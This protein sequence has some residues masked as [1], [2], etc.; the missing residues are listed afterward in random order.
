MTQRHLAAWRLS[1]YVLLVFR[2]LHFLKYVFFVTIQQSVIGGH[3]DRCDSI[4][5][6]FG[7]IRDRLIDWAQLIYNTLNYV[8]GKFDNQVEILQL[9][10]IRIRGPH[11]A[12]GNIYIYDQGRKRVNCNDRD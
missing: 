8:F 10:Y 7:Y 4:C 6:H 5:S 12:I 3:L 1:D 9:Q 2:L 11:L